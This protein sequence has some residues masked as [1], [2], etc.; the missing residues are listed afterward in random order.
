MSRPE[1]VFFFNAKEEK[2]TKISLLQPVKVKF[3][4]NLYLKENLI[5]VAVQDPDMFTPGIENKTNCALINEE[6]EKCRFTV[7]ISVTL[8]NSGPHIGGRGDVRG[9]R[10]SAV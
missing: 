4:V 9:G 7:P 6:V 3:L 1:L 2:T 10:D 8:S 5:I